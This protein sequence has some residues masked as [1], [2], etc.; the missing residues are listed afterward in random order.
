MQN[1][2]LGISKTVAYFLGLHYS[3]NNIIFLERIR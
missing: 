1:S 3:K 2:Q